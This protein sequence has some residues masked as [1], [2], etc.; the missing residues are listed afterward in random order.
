MKCETCGGRGFTELEHGL[1]MIKCQECGGT[2]EL[3]NIPK[4][5]LLSE[6]MGDGESLEELEAKARKII[7]SR[8]R[9]TRKQ[10]ASKK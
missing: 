3:D 7:N 8:T 10:K 4:A 2:G 9:K 5:L 1:V 6:R